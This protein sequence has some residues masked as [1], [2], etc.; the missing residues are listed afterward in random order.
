[1]PVP[2][3]LK[4]TQKAF[5]HLQT[6]IGFKAARLV[7]Q[8]SVDGEGDEMFHEKC[9]KRG[10]TIVVAELEEGGFIGAYTSVYWKQTTQFMWRDD[11]SAF[12]F[13]IK[14]A[15]SEKVEK[16]KQIAYPQNAVFHSE[17]GG[18]TFGAGDFSISLKDP[19]TFRGGNS[20]TYEPHGVAKGTPLKDVFVYAVRI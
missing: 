12:L 11:L 1:M 13:R 9:N 5:E 4:M 10:A 6:L 14:S 3:G 2:D 18:P 15:E 19:L 8:W 7:Y 17:N 20:Y 16:Y